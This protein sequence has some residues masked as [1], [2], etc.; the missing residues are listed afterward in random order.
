MKRISLLLLSIMLLF[1]G[2]GKRIQPPSAQRIEE[3]YQE[4]REEFQIIAD[5]LLPQ[6]KNIAIY[7]SQDLQSAPA[8]VK[9]ADEILR[10]KA[11]CYSI[12]R[13]GNTVTFILWTRF[14]DAGCG[15]AYTTADSPEPDMTFLTQLE[16][17]SESGW[18]YYVEDYAQWRAQ[19]NT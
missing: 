5:Y 2:C 16:A 13:H 4:Y 14:T 3:I 18:F 19:R 6:E 9:K 10:K 1:S 7:S 8:N 12:H 11:G 15:I 17:L